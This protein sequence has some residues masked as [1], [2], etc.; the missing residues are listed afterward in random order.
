M[1]L[2]SVVIPNFNSGQLLRKSL[3]SIAGN[4][5]FIDLE[6]V[7]VDNLSSD[8]PSEIVNDFLFL[9]IKFIIESDFGVYDAM[10]KGVDCSNGNW[11]FFLG[12]G[13]ELIL[14]SLSVDLFDNTFDYFYGKAFDVEKQKEVGKKTKLYDLFRYGICHQTIF[15]KKSVFDNFRFDLRFPIQADLVFNI[16]VFSSAKFNGRFVDQIFCNYL[17]HGLSSKHKDEMFKKRKYILLAHNLFR[18]PSF[19]NLKNTVQYL[20]FKMVSKF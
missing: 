12:A 5:S 10:N 13:D 14:D 15:Y 6:V 3:E 11:L 20:R 4:S 8:H 7:I 9:S 16:S 1:T 2:L 18:N 19:S 17:G